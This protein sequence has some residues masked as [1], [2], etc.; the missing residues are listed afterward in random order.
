MTDVPSV[1]NLCI[2][3]HQI[4]GDFSQH[5]FENFQKALTIKQ[6]E[7]IQNASKMRVDVR[8]YCELLSIGIFSNKV[9]LKYDKVI[10]F[11]NQEKIY[12]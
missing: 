2:Q 6:G 10:I 11:R 3:F 12:F 9:Y 1:V 8:L 5:L 4:Y 7:K